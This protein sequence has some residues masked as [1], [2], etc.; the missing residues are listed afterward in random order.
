M[1][2]PSKSAEINRGAYL[3]EGPGHCGECHTPRNW[4]GGTIDGQEALRR[5]EPGRQR[6]RPQYHA[7]WHGARI[8][9]P[10]GHCLCARNRLHTRGRR[11]RRLDGEG[12]GKYGET[13]VRGSGGDR[14]LSQ[15]NSADCE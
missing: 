4:L 9:E 15:V 11:H 7:R 5:A 3:V 2:D 1:A 12:A 14:R 10:E 6:L 13:D 8:L